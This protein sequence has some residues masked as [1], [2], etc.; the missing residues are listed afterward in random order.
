[1]L[2]VQQLFL[3]NA[4]YTKADF[5]D[6]LKNMSQHTTYLTLMLMCLCLQITTLILLRVMKNKTGMPSNTTKLLFIIVI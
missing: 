6:E 2:I 5:G 4:R 1:M 3:P